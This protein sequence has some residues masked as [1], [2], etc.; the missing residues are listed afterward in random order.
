MGTYRRCRLSPPPPLS[1]NQYYLK[2]NQ[3]SEIRSSG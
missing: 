3:P 1:R 2:A